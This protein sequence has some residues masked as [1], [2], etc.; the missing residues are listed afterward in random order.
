MPQLTIQQAF[1]LAHAHHRAG[2]LR[3]AESIYQQ[4]LAH[5]PQHAD[6]LN[7]LGAIA[8]QSG[9]PEKAANLI[10]QSIALKPDVAEAYNNLAIV[11]MD[12]GQL[13]EA[14]S[15][16]RQ[17]LSLK[18]DIPGTHSNLGNALR[19]RG[20]IDEAIATCRKAIRL[21][22]EHAAAHNNLG[23]A[24]KDKGL[25]DDAI[26][27][28]RQAIALSPSYAEAHHNLGNA[29]MDK[30]L[31]DA[32]IAESREATALKPDL[33]EA[34]MSLGNALADQ[35]SLEQS[36]HA[37]RQARQALALKAD[38]ADAR[39]NLALMLLAR[40]DFEEGWAEHEWRY[41]SA[42]RNFKQ[43]RW[44]GG[45]L[46]GQT[47]LLH[48]E[49]GLGDTLQFIRY[50]PMVAKRGGRIIVECQR[51]LQRLIQGMDANFQVVAR[52]ER[53]PEF[54]LHC[55]LLSLPFIF[56]TTLESI[57]HTVPYLMPDQNLQQLWRQRLNASGDG[58]KIG[59]VWAG[60]PEHKKDRARSIPA[61]R[62]APLAQLQGATFFSLQK[63]PAQQQ[64]IPELR[65]IQLSPE[66]QDFADTAAAISLMDLI[67]SVDTSVAHLAG[68]LG[69]AVWV[70]LPYSAD[71]RWLQKREDSPWYPTMRLFRQP[72]R[73]DWKSVLRQLVS[74]LSLFNH[75][76]P[77]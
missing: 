59:L 25:L 16:W 15:N 21:A 49:Q 73:G 57:P 28:Y 37:F 39:H 56:K 10:R 11:L 33:P 19:E 1:N 41:P 74:A 75:T 58:T 46:E 48:A 36:I 70:M 64:E 47:I 45:L 2:R 35:G 23:L 60:N 12:M 43:P 67:I 65:L 72:A 20:E 5:R 3:E 6:V 76:S 8:G 50:A 38:Q 52:G 42:R 9:Q 4:I 24:L 32:A 7:M 63:G 55:P 34:W 68:A 29:L 14:I 71:W 27:A 62:L 30:G 17:A 22:P 54:D 31:L 53:L 77:T 40:G 69:K 51:E 18:P 44:D 61:D 66:L 13:D 26:V